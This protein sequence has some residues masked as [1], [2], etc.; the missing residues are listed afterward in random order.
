[1]KSAISHKESLPSQIIIKRRRLED[2]TKVTEDTKGDS[3]KAECTQKDSLSMPV[4]KNDEIRSSSPSECE[5][6]DDLE[7]EQERLQQLRNAKLRETPGGKSQ[8]MNWNYDVL[9]QDKS[10]REREAQDIRNDKQESVAY[11]KFMKK[12]FK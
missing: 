5:S 4:K 7:L 8:N 2:V 1:M 6:D 3:H 10:R 9:F 11:K 12:M